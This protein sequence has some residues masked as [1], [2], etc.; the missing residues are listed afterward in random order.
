MLMDYYMLVNRASQSIHT[1]ESHKLL[2]EKSK[3]KNKSVLCHLYKSQKHAEQYYI[4]L[5]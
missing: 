5:E 4:V 2:S 1:G 3:L